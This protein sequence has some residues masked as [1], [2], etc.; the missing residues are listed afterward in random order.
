MEYAEPTDEELIALYCTYPIGAGASVDWS[1]VSAL[2]ICHLCG[3]QGGVSFEEDDAR[4]DA[5]EHLRLEHG[6]QPKAEPVCRASFCVKA[7]SSRGL[8]ASH[9]HR[10]QDAWRGIVGPWCSV[11]GCAAGASVKGLC[12]SHYKKPTE[13]RAS[14]GAVFRMPK[15]P[16]TDKEPVWHEGGLWRECDMCETR[17]F[18]GT[19]C[20]RHYNTT[21]ERLKKVWLDEQA[22]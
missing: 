6:P 22:A 9:R 2:F 17:T 19:L 4:S 5:I 1:G 8:C 15:G 16:L 3:L 11:D 21:R 7:A 14:A 12:K 10:A 13:P 20:S 18:S